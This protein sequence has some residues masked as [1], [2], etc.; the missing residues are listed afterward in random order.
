MQPTPAPTSGPASPAPAPMED[1]SQQPFPEQPYNADTLPFHVLTAFFEKLQS[2]RKQE[3]RRRLLNHWFNKW[4]EDNGPDLFP[5]LRLLLPHRDRERSVYGLKEKALAKLYIKVIPLN[6]ND[7]D[8]QRLL[9][10]K[11]PTEKNAASGDFPTVL[12]E[13]VRKRSSVTSSSLT[14][15]E[16]NDMLDQLA[17]TSNK[18][19][20]QA[21]VIQR[22]Y[23]EA[24]AEEQLWFARII[25]KDMNIS[26]KETTVFAVFHPDAQALYNTCSDL[27]KV[28]W[29]LAD[30][31]IRL[32]EKD[33]NVKI[34]Q[35]FLPML[36]K[37]PTRRIEDTVKE[38]GGSEFIIEEKLDG[39]R[40]QLHKNGNQFY[41]CSRKGKDYTY[42]YGAHV[43][44]G[45]LTPHIAKQFH[46]QADNLILDGEMLVWDPVSGRNLP[47]G[48]L[49]TA[50]LDQSKKQGAPRPCLKVFDLLY[51]NGQSL[52]NKS[53]A[54]RKKN[55]KL[56]VNMVP[57]RIEF[58]DEFRG[59]TAQ[60]IRDRMDEVMA[61]RGE[62]LVIKHPKSQYV[63]NGRNN[64]WIKV[65]PEYMDNMGETVDVL[66][67]AGNYGTGKRS[68]G[69][70]T[71]I[72]A[73]Y[74]DRRAEQGEDDVKYSTFV[75]VGSGL[76]FADYIWIRSKNWKTWD[77]KNPPKH[78]QTAKRS[79]E[80]KG[81]VYLD[82]EDAFI[83]KVKAAEITASAID[84]YHM[85]YTMRFPR[86]LSIRDEMLPSDC[87]TASAVLAQLKS[88]K[89][90]KMETNAI[91]LRKKRKV[92]TKKKVEM[93]NQFEM[94]DLKD[95]KAESDL[96]KGMKFVVISDPKARN[97]EEDKK[98][99]IKLI[100][101]HGGQCPQFAKDPAAIVVYGGM[102][103]PYDL[104]L[105]IRKDTNDV[106]R[107]QWVIDCI[108]QGELVPMEKKY[109]FF[110]TSERK[111]SDEFGGEEGAG[112]EGSVTEE[113]SDEEVQAPSEGT[114]KRK[115]TPKSADSEP[116][117]AAKTGDEEASGP[118]PKPKVELDPEL[119]AWL[120]YDGE[121]EETTHEPNR[122]GDATEA[123]SDNDSDNADVQNEEDAKEDDDMDFWL[124]DDRD[125]T[126]ATRSALQDTQIRNDAPAHVD[127][128]KMGDDNAMHYDEDLIFKHLCFYLDSPSNARANGMSVKSTKHEVDINKSFAELQDKIESNGGQVVDLSEPK[129]THVVLDK[130]DLSRRI[131]LMKRT[132]KPKRRHLVLPAYIDACLEENTLLD[133]D[134]ESGHAPCRLTWAFADPPIQ[135]LRPR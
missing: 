72:C 47:F 116:E 115:R 58:A 74:D 32:G 56:C 60:D 128:I 112:S 13:V 37:R 105:I 122:K 100:R 113:S 82:V 55:M 24:T 107:P 43:G 125:D 95:V 7:Q 20:K 46:K 30:P 94:P 38:M 119:A 11:K 53:T 104:Q 39:E 131:D 101:S 130:R 71:L 78:I 50:A 108:A 91:S 42:L 85:R 120:G 84:Q 45:S 111:T 3:K 25:L 61:N 64:D 124:N 57:G 51:L 4:R 133:E 80:D 27:K 9:F 126:E 8:A 70:S 63:L 135:T 97:G 17:D 86:A 44:I 14:I 21:R 79:H 110:A 19:E 66:V 93:L 59:R 109:F 12:Y 132:S 96:F 90:R 87:M 88:E 29:Q 33:K 10:W 117:P 102:S 103:T 121:D 73:V 89:Q 1:A 106:M 35:S 118:P 62:G 26:V 28:A 6:K 52:L 2:E 75:R 98:G 67:I 18:S 77:P 23:N 48:T 129:L 22:L 83:L 134:G 36:C 54:F 15:D 65:K 41:Y 16:I 99:L 81:D 5:V 114:R 76:T 49:K 69:V 31:T 34:F 40:M 68:G 127:D 123:D 92:T